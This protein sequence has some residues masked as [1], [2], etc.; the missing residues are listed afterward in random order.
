[1]KK[2]KLFGYE[3][4]KSYRNVLVFFY[5]ILYVYGELGKLIM[6]N[7]EIIFKLGFKIWCWIVNI[8][9]WWD[10]E[11]IYIVFNIIKNVLLF[12]VDENEMYFGIYIFLC[13]GNNEMS[14]IWCLK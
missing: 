3:I 1:M 8:N 9:K 2:E 13:I 14:L 6:V 12:I 5:F 7:L 11:Y 4:V 10:I